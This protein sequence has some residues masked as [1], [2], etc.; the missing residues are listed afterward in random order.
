MNRRIAARGRRDRHGRRCR[1]RGRG[2]RFGQADPDANAGQGD[3]AAARDLEAARV[4]AGRLDAAAGAAMSRERDASLAVLQLWPAGV[5]GHDAAVP[6]QHG[7]LGRPRPDGTRRSTWFTGAGASTAPSPRAETVLAR[8]DHRRLDQRHAGRATPT[9][10]ASTWPTGSSADSAAREWAG[11][12]A[13]YYQTDSAGNK[14]V[15]HATR[16]TS[17]AGIW[18]DDGNDAAALASTSS[19]N[20]PGPTNTYTDLGQRRR[21]R[22]RIS[23]SPICPTPT[24]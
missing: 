9:A 13:Q 1:R 14:T 5:P 21:V 23:A 22:W 6:R 24:S 3:Q 4:R 18:V 17:S 2:H 7:L 20:P 12:Q 15:H 19:S 8:D 11:V 16:P 10:P